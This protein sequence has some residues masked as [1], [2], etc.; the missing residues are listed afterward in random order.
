MEKKK[1]MTHSHCPQQKTQTSLIHEIEM[2]WP[3]QIA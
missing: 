3:E 1:T 2:Q